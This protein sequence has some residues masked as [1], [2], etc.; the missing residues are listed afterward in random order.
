MVCSSR[1]GCKKEKVIHVSCGPR[2]SF[3]QSTKEIAELAIRNT[4]SF[5]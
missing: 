3:S 2:E 4:K 5:G 1:E